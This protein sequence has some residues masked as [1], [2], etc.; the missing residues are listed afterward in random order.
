MDQGQAVAPAAPAA[1]DSALRRAIAWLQSLDPVELLLVLVLIALCVLIKVLWLQDINIYWDAVAKWHFVRQWS[2]ANDFS[3]EAW[4]HHM[5]RF[6]VH[7]PVYLVQKVLGTATRVYYVVPVAMHT[8]Q[9]LFVYLLGRHLAGRSAGVLGA[10]LM[11]FFTGMTINAS[12]LLPDGFVATV[13]LMGGYAF[14]RFHE[15]EGKARP[16]WLLAVGLSCIWAYAIKESSVL[17]FPGFALAVLLSKRSW[18]EAAI[19][20]GMIAAY[21][22][23]ETAAF[24]LFTNYSHRLAVVRQGHEP[25]P[26]ITFWQL[27]DRFGELS[28]SWQMLFWLWLAAVLYDLGSGDKRR[29]LLLLLPVGY[30]FLLTFMVRSINPIQQWLSA[31]PRYITPAGGF[32][33]LG[34]ALFVHDTVA[35]AWTTWRRPQWLGWVEQRL[36]SF[37]VLAI[38][39]CWATGLLFF[40]AERPSFDRHPLT[41]LRREASIVNDA[42]RRNLPIVE[43]SSK[44]R[45]LYTLYGLFLQPKYLVQSDVAKGGIL[46]NIKDGVRRSRRGKKYAYVLRDDSVY[47]RREMDELVKRG[48]AV[49]VRGRG[50]I[51]LNVDEKL[52]ERCKAPR[53]KAIPK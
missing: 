22:A 37:S 47:R 35:R 19:L 7:V 40:I 21:G 18:K 8:L 44:P 49:V 4:T 2:Y 25:Y 52:P 1:R 41:E 26:P 33:V 32:F 3:N 20:V 46:P 14:V 10:L 17:L 13:A 42:F 50:G 12:Q 24:N 51:N 27:F 38:V 45:G 39:L 16:Y 11:I 31:K 9:M 28:A 5:A 6:G 15:A 48:C 43:D 23:L 30:V 36:P 34:T 29:R 53:G